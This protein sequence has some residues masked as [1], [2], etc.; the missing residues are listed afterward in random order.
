MLAIWR[1]YAFAL[2]AAA[3]VLVAAP[4]Q[5]GASD[6]GKKWEVGAGVAYSVYDN[7]STLG[8]DFATSVRGGYHFRPQHGVEVSLQFQSTESS[9]RGS[10]DTYDVQ[11]WALNYLFNFKPKKE[12]SKLAPLILFGVGQMDWDRGDS[13]AGS[14]L[15]QAGGGVRVLFKP[16]IA[17]RVDG[18]LFHYY[19]DR[20]L[21][22]RDSFF[23]FDADVGVSFFFGG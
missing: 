19:G 16:W 8:D 14:T 17:L 5:A 1:R 22:P 3:G 9:T 12:D 10:T 11:R 7:D 20:D 18:R 15:I 23:G 6:L 21:I 4:G 2:A 13:S